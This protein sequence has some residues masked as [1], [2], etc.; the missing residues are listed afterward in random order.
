MTE[1]NHPA[2]DPTM[3]IYCGPCKIVHAMAYDRR[4]GRY[5][6]PQTFDVT[7]C[8]AC[9]VSDA[10]WAAVDARQKATN[11]NDFYGAALKAN[12]AMGMEYAEARRRA[13]QDTRARFDNASR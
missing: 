13:L 3:R 11:R 5:V 7:N 10:Y 12:R 4:S 9:Q 2:A 8:P 1:H 6:C